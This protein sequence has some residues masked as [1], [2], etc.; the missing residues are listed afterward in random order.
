[1]SKDYQVTVPF[2]MESEGNRAILSTILLRFARSWTV[3]GGLAYGVVLLPLRRVKFGR[4]FLERRCDA[5]YH[6]STKK[7]GHR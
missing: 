1:M 5:R 7:G 4:D 3:V 2:D 6:D